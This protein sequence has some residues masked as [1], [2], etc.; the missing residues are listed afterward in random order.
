MT[1]RRVT[2]EEREFRRSLKEAEERG[3]AIAQAEIDAEHAKREAAR[4]AEPAI[5]EY[6]SAIN[7]ETTLH[8]RA[9]DLAQRKGYLLVRLAARFVCKCSAPD[10]V[11]CTAAAICSEIDVHR[12]RI[13][14][15][16]PAYDEA[17]VRVHTALGEPEYAAI[18][19]R[20]IDERRERAQ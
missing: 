6:E 9:A 15:N 13:Y 20:S 19:Q 11:V 3:R 17:M 8:A 18:F 7:A 5:A 2:A 14:A 4:A 16:A 10:C 12:E 1:K